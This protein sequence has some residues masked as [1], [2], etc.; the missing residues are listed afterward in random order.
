MCI[1]CYDIAYLG[2]TLLLW[3]TTKLNT[4]LPLLKPLESPPYFFATFNYLGINSILVRITTPLHA[5]TS[6][7]FPLVAMLPHCRLYHT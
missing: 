5:V 2:A 1:L 4:N 7:W 3:T 6:S